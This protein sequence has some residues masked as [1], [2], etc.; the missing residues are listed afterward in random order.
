MTPTHPHTH[1]H[2]SLPTARLAS[3]ILFP[4]SARNCLARFPPAGQ[5]RPLEPVVGRRKG[6]KRK[7]KTREKEQEKEHEEDEDPCR[8]L[9]WASWPGQSP[10]PPSHELKRRKSGE[11]HRGQREREHHD[12]I[13]GAA[14]DY[15]I[16]ELVQSLASRSVSVSPSSGQA[17]RWFQQISRTRTCSPVVGWAGMEE[18]GREGRKGILHSGGGGADGCLLVPPLLTQCTS[19]YAKA[20]RGC[21]FVTSFNFYFWKMFILLRAFGRLPCVCT[22]TEL[23]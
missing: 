17:G 1:Q 11:T 21:L 8:L 2:S 4:P 14:C 19:H 9:S 16:G 7:G 18:G 3:A 20:D 13:R 6:K 15:H 5:P 10:P 12:R 22:W 23:A